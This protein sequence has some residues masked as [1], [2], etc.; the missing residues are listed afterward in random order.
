MMQDKPLENPIR[1]KFAA[2]PGVVRMGLIA[3]GVIVGITV[4]SG[5]LSTIVPKEDKTTQPLN[6]V[7]PDQAPSPSPTA[8]TDLEMQRQTAWQEVRQSREQLLSSLAEVD[9]ALRISR[10]QKW[11][12][13]A[14]QEC[15]REGAHKCPSTYKWLLDRYTTAAAEIQREMF[16]GQSFS[17]L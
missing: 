15:Q 16:A 9:N 4:V 10:A 1:A 6:L 7:Q 14:A 5:V 13:Y 17:G 12:T 11:Q 8:A 2:L 3:G